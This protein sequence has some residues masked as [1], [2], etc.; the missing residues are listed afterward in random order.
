MCGKLPARR[1]PV[2]RGEKMN[3]LFVGKGEGILRQ[4][5]GSGELEK[6]NIDCVLWAKTCGEAKELLGVR[7]IP[8][9]FTQTDLPDGSG[10]DLL[11]FLRS[12]RKRLTVI[13]CAQTLDLPTVRQ[14]MRLHAYD[15]VV[16]ELSGA[17][18]SELLRFAAEG[19]RVNRRIDLFYQSVSDI[20]QQ[21]RSGYWT[22]LLLSQNADAAKTTATH[23]LGYYKDYNLSTVFFLCVLSLSDGSETAVPWK[24]YAMRNVF[25]E[26]AEKKGLRLDAVLQIADGDSCCVLRAEKRIPIETVHG[27][28]TD[29]TEFVEHELGGWVNCYYSEEAHLN[30]ARA[31]FEPLIACLE[32]DVASHGTV[33]RAADYEPRALP[34]SL[35]QIQEWELLV[36]Y[37]QADELVARIHTF[38]DRLASRGDVNRAF[39]KSLRIQMMQMLQSVLKERSIGAYDIY[40]EPRFD[41]LRENSLRSVEH[42]KRYLEYIVRSAISYLDTVSETQSVVGRV[43]DYIDHHFNEDI[44]RNSVARTVFLNPDYLARV[45][46]RET[47]KSLGAYIKDRRILE[48]KKLLAETDV[49]INE[50]AIRVGYDNSSYFSHI[51]HEYTGLSP[52]EYR[53]RYVDK[54]SGR[55]AKS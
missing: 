35:P 48:A 40:A 7:E 25:Q 18:I 9:V 41:T 33:I 32:D 29:L 27:V 1:T 49:Q 2:E 31:A 20:R 55:S 46:K 22:E 39:L 6:Y 37:R 26:L 38:L 21:N 23:L 5:A 47:G 24:E 14:A 12:I 34:Y 30:T 19:I 54:R 42:M 8:L 43:K 4:I 50:I 16:G 11:L 17:E 52:N 53:R 13:F 44:S 36:N 3:V 45:F 51:F 15:Y 28:L 10:I